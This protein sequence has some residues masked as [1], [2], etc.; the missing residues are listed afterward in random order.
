MLADRRGGLPLRHR[1]PARGQR[2]LATSSRSPLFAV[3]DGM[4]GAQAGEVASSIAAE[5]FD[6]SERGSDA[7]PR[8]TCA[9]SP[10]AANSRI[11]ELAQEDASRSGMGTTLTAALLDGE[12]LSLAHVGDSRAYRLRDGE[13]RCSP[14]TT[15]WSRS[16]AARAASP[17]S[18][19]RTTRSARSSPGRSGPSRRSRSTR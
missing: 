17:T 16:S 5:A 9:G 12:E 13:L 10:Q 15:R 2:G 11:H 8:P 1:P 14:P 4:G 6:G 7:R 18:R 19:P 3:A